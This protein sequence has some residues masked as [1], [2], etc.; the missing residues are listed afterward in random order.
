LHGLQHQ[1]QP[2]A[3]VGMA[4]FT[5]KDIAHSAGCGLIDDQGFPRSGRGWHL[6][7][8]V[9]I[10]FTPVATYVDRVGSA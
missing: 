5:E 6:T 4:S 7:S 9:I 2:R 1:S 8:R 3:L 10:S